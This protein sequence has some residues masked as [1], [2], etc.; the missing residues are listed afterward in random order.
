MSF[1]SAPDPAGGYSGCFLE[2]Y[3]PWQQSS[4]GAGRHGRRHQQL[5]HH[6]LG[7][8]VVVQG[9]ARLGGRLI[10]VLIRELIE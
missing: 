1:R 6:Q 2:T 8:V 7:V 10:G 9:G 4:N 5:V 3:I